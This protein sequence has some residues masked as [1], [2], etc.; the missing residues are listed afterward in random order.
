MGSLSRIPSAGATLL[1]TFCKKLDV[2]PLPPSNTVTFPSWICF[3]CL[4]LFPKRFPSIGQPS[5]IGW[6]FRDCARQPSP[7]P[8][9]LPLSASKDSSCL[10][11]SASSF[12]WMALASACA[13]ARIASAS[14]FALRF[15]CSAN[16]SASKMACCLAIS[17]DNLIRFQGLFHFA[18]FSL[19][20]I[21]RCAFSCA[22]R[23]AACV[24][25][26]ASPAFLEA[27][28]W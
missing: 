12:I 20:S 17:A 8:R 5:C 27:S 28:A 6:R 3:K 23:T 11:A 26:C 22:V 4:N 21:S 19:S 1:T 14:A 7:W 2:V 15:I 10:S 18:G 13:L 9:N 25:A 16:A 24:R